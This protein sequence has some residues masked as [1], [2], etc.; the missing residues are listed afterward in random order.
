MLRRK[1]EINRREKRKDIE[2]VDILNSTGREREINFASQMRNYQVQW[3]RRMRQ[4][5]KVREVGIERNREGGRLKK[6]RE[7]GGSRIER[8]RESK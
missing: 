3:Q 5:E 8:E 1:K 7:R 4:K 6:K 2:D